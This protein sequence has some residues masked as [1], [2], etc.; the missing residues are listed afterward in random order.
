MR[1]LIIRIEKYLYFALFMWPRVEDYIVNVYVGII[2]QRY[3]QGHKCPPQPLGVT[4][5]MV[6]GGH[7]WTTNAMQNNLLNIVGRVK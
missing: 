7:H 1:Y 4:W 2:R 5:E 3:L 6:N